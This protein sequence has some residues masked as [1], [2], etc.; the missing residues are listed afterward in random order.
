M[1]HLDG[2]ELAQLYGEHGEQLLQQNIRV[3]QGDRATNASIKQTAVGGESANFFHY[4]NGVTFLCETAEWD[5][6]ISKLT[7]HKG[8]IVNGGQT[9]RVLYDAFQG[10]ALKDDVLVP[11]RVI[12]SQ[13]DKDFGNNV[14][15][16]LNNQT[17]LGS[18][19]LR[20]ND[21]RVVQLANALA[22][23][24]WYLERREDEVKQLSGSERESPLNNV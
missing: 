7:L 6:F 24:G 23:L 13:G 14:A 12:T 18:S 21:P 15:V 10:T 22:S 5:Q 3:Y 2:T 16:N 19:F 9:I 11:V 1:F 4:N 8:Q 17:R 20:S